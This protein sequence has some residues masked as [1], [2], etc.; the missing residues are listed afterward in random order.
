MYIWYEAT[1]DLRVLPRA[2]AVLVMLLLRSLPRWANGM[3]ANLAPE[4]GRGQTKPEESPWRSKG[5]CV[6]SCPLAPLRVTRLG[7][8]SL[9]MPLRFAQGGSSTSRPAP[10]GGDDLSRGP[11]PHPEQ[12]GFRRVVPH[13]PGHALA[14]Q[15]VQERIGVQLLGRAH[16]GSAPP[17]LVHQAG[18]NDRRDARLVRRRLHAE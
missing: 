6:K 18:G 16:A 1:S 10:L 17:S 7:G 8:M 11:K 4:S 5:A 14:G 12:L 2:V 15:P 13:M 9:G 3:R